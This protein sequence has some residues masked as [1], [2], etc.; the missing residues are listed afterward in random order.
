MKGRTRG[1][2]QSQISD[3]R[4]IYICMYFTV[5]D[6]QWNDQGCFSDKFDLC[7]S[8]N[9]EVHTSAGQSSMPT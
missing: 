3:S 6:E 8:R 1:S 7:Y 4:Y 2:R 9:C 5:Q